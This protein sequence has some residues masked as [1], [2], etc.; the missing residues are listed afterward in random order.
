[1][2]AKGCIYHI[3]RVRDVEGGGQRAN[4]FYALHG[5]Q[6]VAD[7]PDVVTI[8]LKVFHFDVYALLDLG[9]NLSVV[10]PFLSNRFDVVP[11]LL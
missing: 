3:V 11:K 2:I 10:T 7:A 9:A 5:R 8:T 6:E 4:R 1:M